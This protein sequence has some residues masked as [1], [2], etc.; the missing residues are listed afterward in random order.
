M[1][2][3]TPKSLI[4]TKTQVILANSYMAESSAYT[5]YTY[6]SQA[7]QKESYFQYANIFAETAENELHHGKI[8]LRYLK[9]G[10]VDTASLRVDAGV[11]GTTAENLAVA[12]QEEQTEGVEA[13][14]NA[15]EVAREEGFDDIASH[16]EAIA[17]VEMHHKER[18]DLMRKR[19]EDGTVWKR[20]KPIKWQCLVCGY[21]FEGTEPPKVCPAC[22]HPYQHY[23]PMEDNI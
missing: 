8:F 7:A 12:A 1:N 18:F 15:A 16:F 11:I 20:E 14:T 2:N 4:G 13:Y 19:I 6:F 5:R 21:I 22:N 10:G 17:K 9:E 3:N 23:M